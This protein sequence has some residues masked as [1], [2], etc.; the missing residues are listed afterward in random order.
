MKNGVICL[1]EALIDF[2]PTDE[3]NLIYEKCPGGAPANVAAGLKRFGIYSTFIGKVGDDML[4]RFLKETLENEGVDASEVVVTSEAR[5]GLTFVNLDGNGERNFQFYI[6]PSADQFLS[7]EEVHEATFLNKKILHIGSISMI[8][9]PA[10]SATKK[11]I[12]VA[13]EN[14]LWLSFDPNLRMDLW[15]NPQIAHERI[16]NVLPETDILKVSEDELLFI[17]GEKDIQQAIQTL[18]KTYSIPLVFITLGANGSIA[19]INDTTIQVPC[20]KIQPIDT[21]GAGDAFVAGI[22][23]GLNQCEKNLS[24]LQQKEIFDI[25]TFANV[26][27]AIMASKK[28]V[29][30]AL[31]SVE[32]VKGFIVSYEK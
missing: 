29:M 21:T 16:T 15:E 31:P 13:K 9:E 14:G 17:T 18:K 27:G 11:A 2:T 23:R 3:T 4:G 8:R 1:G 28:G 26:A 7:M 10:M 25:V 24:S 6:H 20:S 32:A 5:T 19:V 12:Q 30:K 22:L